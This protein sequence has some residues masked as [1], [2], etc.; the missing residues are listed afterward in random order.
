MPAVSQTVLIDTTNQQTVLDKKATIAVGN[1][2]RQREV[3]DT[4]YT[5]SK[6]LIDSLYSQIDIHKDEANEIKTV[7]I[8][9]LKNLVKEKDNELLQTT[10]RASLIETD[11]AVK[12]KAQKNKKWYWLLIGVVSGFFASLIL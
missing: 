9:T 7:T 11:L 10:K 12:L 8:P 6:V 1:L 5:E 4:L 3:L 2:L